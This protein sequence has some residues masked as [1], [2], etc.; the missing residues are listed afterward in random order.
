VFNSSFRRKWDLVVKSGGL[1]IFMDVVM[2]VDLRVV[3]G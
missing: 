1:W 2:E 3:S